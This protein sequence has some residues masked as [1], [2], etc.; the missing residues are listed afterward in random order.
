MTSRTLS[1]RPL[2]NRVERREPKH[3]H[4]PGPP[5]E[6][7][8][9]G[10]RVLEWR[11]TPLRLASILAVSAGVRQPVGRLASP[12]VWGRSQP[13]QTAGRQRGTRDT[14]E[15]CTAHT[16][17]PGRRTHTRCV[18]QRPSGWAG[19]ALPL[20]YACLP[21]PCSGNRCRPPGS[22]VG[23]HQASWLRRIDPPVGSER[24]GTLTMSSLL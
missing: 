14:H 4:L 17:A 23:D 15:P 24:M 16:S 19:A 7:E 5:H 11:L 10:K 3:R 1:E 6:R 9:A 8:I 20:R 18:R 22:T 2:G 21:D 12:V 13:L